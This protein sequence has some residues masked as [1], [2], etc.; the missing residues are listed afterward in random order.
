MPTLYTKAPPWGGRIPWSWKTDTDLNQNLADELTPN[1]PLIDVVND[2]SWTLTPTRSQARKEAPFIFLREY[3]QLETQL[4]QCLLPYGRER[5]GAD[6]LFKFSN[7]FSKPQDFLGDVYNFVGEASTFLDLLDLKLD[8]IYKGLFDHLV[9]TNFQY[10]LPYFTSEYFSIQ[11]NWSGVDVLDTIV[12]LQSKSLGFGQGIFKLLTEGKKRT[13]DNNET[14]QQKSISVAS[15]PETL[16][17]IEIFNLQSKSPAV[18][19]M[20]PP[21]VWKSTNHRQYTFQFPLYNIT[22]TNSSKSTEEIIK[23]WE[24]CYLLTYQNVVNKRNYFTAV[25]PVFYEVEIPGVHY[26]KASYISTLNIQNIGNIRR[27]RLSINDHS[28]VPVNVP[29]GY[30]ITITLVDLLTPSKNL[31]A[32]VM[33]TSYKDRIAGVGPDQI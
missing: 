10:K 28:N 21:Y 29:D 3:L 1:L 18:G 20:D 17:N 11:N 15:L 4:N 23:N 33:N 5:V 7:P 14:D 2:F 6:G 8:T 31:L 32:A 24:F 12:N 16:R 25:P 13:V 22:Y 27:L 19:L 9:S 30:L 26:S